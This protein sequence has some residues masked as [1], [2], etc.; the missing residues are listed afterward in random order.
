[1][2][3]DDILITERKRVGKK[4]KN[5]ITVMSVEDFLA[6]ELNEAVHGKTRAMS[7][8]DLQPYLQRAKAKEVKSSE[9]LNMP[10]VHN[11]N[12]QLKDES[13]TEIDTDALRK[14]MTTRPANILQKNEKMK[15]SDGT[16]EQYFNIGLPALRGLAVDE[17]TGEFL[18]VNT[19][20]GAGSCMF[21]CYAM[22]GG[23]VQYPGS[24]L[25]RSKILTW[26]LNDPEGFKAKLM[27]EVGAKKK[28]ADKNGE[29]VAVR[30]HDAGDF[31]SPEYLQI[32]KDVAAAFPDVNFYAYTKS[33]SAMGDTPSN[34][35][36][37]FSDGATKRDTAKINFKTQ[38]SGRI[39]PTSLFSDLLAGGKD[40]TGRWALTDTDE[41]KRR[42]GK[43]YGVDPKTI[44][45][46]VEYSDS[47]KNQHE[48]KWNV[49]V[50]PG[51]SDAPANDK[52]V[53]NVFNLQH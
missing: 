53:L 20:P 26:V 11:K 1:M 24:S 15:H 30:W 28:T 42:V 38:R 16:S 51:G 27:R 44:L 50:V 19:C 17:S 2:K 43:K 7:D 32:A 47:Q 45:M 41:L 22:K 25:F 3:L 49:I 10:L 29:K 18:V 21:D 39:V 6:Q 40:E 13:G 31:F 48:N 34:L 4:K 8:D 46:D 23:F 52:N 33:S 5:G 9:R 36:I 14:K 37:R 12:L 35:D